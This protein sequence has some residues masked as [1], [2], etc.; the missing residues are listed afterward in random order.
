MAAVIVGSIGV[1]V[2]LHPTLPRGGGSIG[3]FVLVFAIANTLNVATMVIAAGSIAR[4]AHRNRPL[5]PFQALRS[6]GS[7]RT[8]SAD[9]MQGVADDRV[10]RL[11]FAVNA[12]A[13]F[14]GAAVPGAAIVVL[15]PPSGWGLLALVGL[16]LAGAM[17]LRRGV[18]R[19]LEQARAVLH[20]A[21]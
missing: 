7:M 4:H 6:F 11:A 13:A 8:W 18:R 14:V 1:T 19:R 12:V 21:P 5:G 20:P 2:V 10:F 15:L 16:D 9:T 17:L 3:W